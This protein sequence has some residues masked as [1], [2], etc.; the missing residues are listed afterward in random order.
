MLPT[1]LFAFERVPEGGV[2]KGIVREAEG[3]GRR[4]Q[5][6]SSVKSGSGSHESR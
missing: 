3:M 2:Q 4:K 5:R 1:L 6:V